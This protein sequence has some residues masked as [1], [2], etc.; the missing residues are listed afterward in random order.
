MFIIPF[1]LSD[2]KKTKKN[3]DTLAPSAMLSA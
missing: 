3:V 2:S 1:S